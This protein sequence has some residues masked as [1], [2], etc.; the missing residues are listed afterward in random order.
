[1]M[2]E[3]SND[4]ELMMSG[5]DITMRPTGGS[6]RELKQVVLGGVPM[7]LIQYVLE[8]DEESVRVKIDT[9]GFDDREGIIRVLEELADTLRGAT[10]VD[11]ITT[12]ENG[13]TAPIDIVDRNGL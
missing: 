5:L 2:D 13:I 11:A 4:D 3:S 1:M 7:L 9:T 8:D 10:V 6:L 12:D